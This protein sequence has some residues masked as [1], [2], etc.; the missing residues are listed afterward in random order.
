MFIC[1]KSF[2]ENEGNAGHGGE[3][4]ALEAT[5]GAWEQENLA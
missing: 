4:E 2:V 5:Q 1:K 3:K